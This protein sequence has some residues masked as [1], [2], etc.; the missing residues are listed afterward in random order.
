MDSFLPPRR[1]ALSEAELQKV[2][3]ELPADKKGLEKAQVILERQATLQASDSAELESWIARM[4][5]I[6]DAKALRAVNQALGLEAAELEAVEIDSTITSSELFTSPIS[7]SRKA[8]RK[9]RR[10]RNSLFI[11]FVTWLAFAGLYS[12]V[13]GYSAFSLTDSLVGLASGLLILGFS[14]FSLITHS[15][16]AFYRSAAAFGAKAFRFWFFTVLIAIFGLLFIYAA[17]FS[18][19][20]EISKYIDATVFGDF[21]LLV[22]VAFS[23]LGLAL[24]ILIPNKSAPWIVLLVCVISVSYLA[25]TTSTPSLN[26][27]LA[28]VSADAL[29][30][31]LLCLVLGGICTVIARPHTQASVLDVVIGQGLALAFVPIVLIIIYQV[32][33]QRIG[34]WVYF[35]SLFA[36]LVC[37][38]TLLKET[39]DSKSWNAILVPLFAGS[40][41]YLSREVIDL[42][43]YLVSFIFGYLVVIATDSWFRRQPL[44]IP[45]LRTRYGFYSAVSTSSM[46]L[47]LAAILLAS[48]LSSLVASSL[49]LA[50]KSE[51]IAALGVLTL[52][53]SRYFVVRAQDKEVANLE[54]PSNRLENLL[55]L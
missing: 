30:S 38:A 33:I 53:F 15:N 29:L 45:S 41:I 49:G 23:V 42:S 20:Q 1:R 21:G 34:F 9:S 19:P 32:G 8:Q 52:S 13:A 6:G 37:L 22:A 46:L 51:V 35:A 55:G 54:T 7:L 4:R 17:D 50:V 16:S 26:F 48:P 27:E 11:T 3:A 39:F 10:T 12:V 36:L 25:F 24:G 43:P 47:L 44:H 28:Q 14:K 5:Q 40:A 31:T 2:L 18:P